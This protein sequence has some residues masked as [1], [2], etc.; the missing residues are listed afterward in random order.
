[1]SDQLIRA[2]HALAHIYDDTGLSNYAGAIAPQVLRMMQ[3]TDWLGR[4]ILVLGCGTGAS[5][6]ALGNAGMDVIGIDFSEDMLSIADMRT[7]NTAYHAQLIH[8]DIR[9][10][11]YPT[12]ID[13]VLCIGSVLNE[14]GSLRE[15]E[16]VFKKAF[17]SLGEGKRL[18]FDLITLRGLGDFI[19]TG[20]QIMDNTDR[21]FYAVENYFNY[22]AMSLR[23]ALTIFVSG[24]VDQWQ[25]FR[26][27]IVLR[28]YPVASISKILQKTGF[29]VLGA[30]APSL[31]SF[32]PND[33][34]D[35]R[36]IIV[37]Q[38]GEGAELQ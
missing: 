15:I 18:V 22:D 29:S 19:G 7:A 14:L 5:M 10:V 9:G 6:A 38:K 8:G 3:Q 37:A 33:D 2:Y 35:G 28:S 24:Q 30:Y 31:E 25:R 27:T 23:Q 34:Q 1:M 4:R 16:L 11:D 32:T 20:E 17:D 26:E 13:M 12:Q 36:V 21:R